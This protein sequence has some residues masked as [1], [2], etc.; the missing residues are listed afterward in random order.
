[1]YQQ[2][3]DS[4]GAIILQKPQISFNKDRQYPNGKKAPDG[5]EVRFG[6]TKPTEE[7]RQMLKAVGFRF[8]EKQTMWY[9][10]DNDKTRAFAEDLATKE[11]E[12]DDA[13]YEK[14]SF[15]KSVGSWSDY[16]D[17]RPRTEFMLKGEPPRFFYS[18][19]QLQ[20]KEDVSRLIRERKLS[21]KRYYNKE[22]GAEDSG[23]PEPT[24][25]AKSGSA[26]ADRLEQLAQ[27]MQKQIDAKVNSA[28]SQQRPTPRRLRI[29]QSMREE[30]YRLQDRQSVLNGLANA[31]RTGTIDNFPFLQK[32]RTL[33]VVEVL[34]R[35]K[36]AKERGWSH[37]PGIFQG[38]K[39]RLGEVGIHSL[40][41][42]QQANDQLTKLLDTH[43]SGAVKQ[44][45]EQEEKL[46]KLEIEIRSMKISGFFPT[47]PDLIA[48]MLSLAQVRSNHDVLE[49]SA[50]KGDIL[51]A[52]SHFLL[53]KNDRLYAIEINPTLREYL[54]LQGHA[55]IGSDFLSYNE[56]LF[57]RILM[58][59]PF[60]NGQDIDHVNH[61]YSLLKPGGALVAIVSE[62]PFFRSFK[63]DVA[64]RAMLEERE[65]YVSKPIKDAF[66]NSFVSTG[67]TVRII[68]L[69]KAVDAPIDSDDMELLELEAEAE[70]ELMRLK[71]EL[72]EKDRN[73]SG[74]ASGKD[75]AK[76]KKLEQ[77]ARSIL[78][79][80]GY[81]NFN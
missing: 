23:E 7:V 37:L 68:A 52:V 28:I 24:P 1:M 49:P 61:A 71:A 12:V 58:N 47:P 54:S 34:L 26:V 60:E 4:L 10:I 81:H 70:L 32:V 76:I 31:H 56:T 79:K 38:S 36:D 9:A 72:K 69:N 66:K 21:Y 77:M 40:E 18:K 64:F 33:A 2:W 63:K 50:G 48:R 73:L 59:P 44:H 8:S 78:G 57:D 46:K 11:L 67:I 29:A 15:W 27:G 39:D 30:G 3:E 17:L 43:N 20:S 75:P 25:V 16:Q 41:D 65:A 53:G 45:R 5:I 80:Q 6:N 42:L 35:F 62:G 19:G 74:V 55:V 22:L 13:Q 14:R 51:N